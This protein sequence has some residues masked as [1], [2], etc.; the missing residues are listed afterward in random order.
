MCPEVSDI[1]DETGEATTVIDCA[2]NYAEYLE[3]ST[4][5]GKKFTYNLIEDDVIHPAI[6]H[7]F[8][9]ADDATDIEE[10]MVSNDKEKFIEGMMYNTLDYNAGLNGLSGEN[11][12]IVYLLKMERTITDASSGNTSTKT[13]YLVYTDYASALAE[14]EKIT[15]ETNETIKEN[16]EQCAQ[17]YK[18]KILY[19]LQGNVHFYDLKVPNINTHTQLGDIIFLYL[20]K[21]FGCTRCKLQSTY[22][23][24]ISNKSYKK[25]LSLNDS[26]SSRFLNQ[27]YSI[28]SKSYGKYE[29]L[30]YVSKNSE[31][32][33]TILLGSLSSYKRT[34]QDIYNS[35]SYGVYI[36]ETNL[37]DTPIYKVFLSEQ[38]SD[39]YSNALYSYRL[40]TRNLFSMCKECSG[41]LLA[42]KSD[43]I[44]LSW[45]DLL[46]PLE[47]M[48]KLSIKKKVVGYY[49]KIYNRIMGCQKADFK[50]RKSSKN[51]KACCLK[52]SN[53]KSGD[54]TFRNLNGSLCHNINTFDSDYVNTIR[55]LL[56]SLTNTINKSSSSDDE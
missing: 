49:N 12:S 40:Y 53:Y 14:L 18:K 3:L 36:V 5:S 4:W 39:A 44:S 42:S 46:M 33:A 25:V 15:G 55:K 13:N 20:T 8:F 54:F 19:T 6:Y 51:K 26:D 43:S 35:D 9:L 27:F 30:S 1:D 31:I 10:G 22:E 2:V 48:K 7:F 21:I 38:A 11:D 23:E 29:C 45:S 16:Y 47:F 34:M 17:C 56:N 37:G 24:P 28:S 32:K 52:C 41:K 50:L